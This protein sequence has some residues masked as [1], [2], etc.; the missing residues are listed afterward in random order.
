[1]SDGLEFGQSIRST[2]VEGKENDADEIN[3]SK[4]KTSQ[5]TIIIISVLTVCI[6]ALIIGIVL[7]LIL[8]NDTPSDEPEPIIEQPQNFS[9]TIEVFKYRKGKGEKE[10]E[11]ENLGLPVY[12]LS[13]EFK[14][15]EK[16]FEVLLDG[17]SV[18]FSKNF[19]FYV[20]GNYTVTYILKKKFESLENLFTNCFYITRIKF[21]YINGANLADTSKMF[22]NCDGLYELNL[23]GLDITNVKKA[24][25]MF[26]G[27]SSLVNLDLSPLNFGKTEDMI[28][29]FYGMEN[30]V[31]LN[32]QNFNTKN[33]ER[34]S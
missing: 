19:T 9:V 14:C 23:T 34:M 26:Y 10:H 13:E 21:D 18:N 6:I 31:N 11:K 32:L 20:E 33:V 16:D 29:M 17:K 4:K 3:P 8:K 27:C 5:K 2:I 15:G 24:S 7:Y 28:S 25:Y 22:Y 12:F 30:L 1:M